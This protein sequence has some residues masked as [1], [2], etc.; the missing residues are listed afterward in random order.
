MALE[1]QDFLFIMGHHTFSSSAAVVHLQT[2]RGTDIP[3][4]GRLMSWGPSSRNVGYA[5]SEKKWEKKDPTSTLIL[6]PAC[7]DLKWE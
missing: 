2:P 5:D 3:Y 6:E 4:A 1:L 7:G